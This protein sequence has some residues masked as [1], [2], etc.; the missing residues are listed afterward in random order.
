MS[1]DP[2]NQ[3]SQNWSDWSEREPVR[4]DPYF[5]PEYPEPSEVLTSD[6]SSASDMPG[7]SRYE[8]AYRDESVSDDQA[9]PQPAVA[10]PPT[11]I[12]VRIGALTEAIGYY[13]NTP[14][15]YV[16]RGELYIES[17]R[18]EQASADFERALDLAQARQESLTWGYV[19]TVLI[20]SV[21]AGLRLVRHIAHVS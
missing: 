10:T 4:F 5:H 7:Q 3:K 21:Y 8:S 1:D 13:P 6:L 17:N 16:L 12:D 19:N 14:V 20:D 11:L 15:N 2:Q 9:L 18:F